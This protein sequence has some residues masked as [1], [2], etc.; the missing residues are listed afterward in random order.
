MTMYGTLTPEERCGQIVHLKERGRQRSDEC[1]TLLRK[2]EN[3]LGFYVANSEENLIRGVA[4][5]GESM[6]KIL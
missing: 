2:E 6:L 3:S 5:A 4:G 1:R